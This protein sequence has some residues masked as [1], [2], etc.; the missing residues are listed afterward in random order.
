MGTFTDFDA[1]PSAS[2]PSPG[3]SPAVADNGIALLEGKL[4]LLDEKMVDLDVRLDNLSQK[5]TERDDIVIELFRMLKESLDSRM[6]FLT[7][8]DEAS[9]SENISGDED[10][11][12]DK[13][14]PNSS[15]VSS[16]K[17]HKQK[18]K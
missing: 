5:R 17:R 6:Q 7:Q 1:K 3:P 15:K 14:P 4:K 12:N 18:A 13:A 2:P 10:D 9:N 8:V 16:L 11:A